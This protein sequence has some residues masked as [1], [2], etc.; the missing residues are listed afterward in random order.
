MT[1]LGKYEAEYY[2]FLDGLRESGITNMFGAATYLEKQFGL[3]KKTSRDVL[4][5]WMKTFG[6]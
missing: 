6:K 4:A 2:E 3:D 5:D 1:P